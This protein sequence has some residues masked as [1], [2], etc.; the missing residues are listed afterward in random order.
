MN[1]LPP[2]DQPG[3]F[4]PM[5]A[6]PLGPSRRGLTGAAVPPG[7]TVPAWLVAVLLLTVSALML[8]NAGLIPSLSS[9]AA[10][11]PRPVTPRGNLA[12]DEKSTIEIFR[13]ASPSVVH[14]TTVTHRRD[15]L[16]L[17]VTEIPEGT[18]T[19]FIYDGEGHV[20]TNFH[21]IRSAQAAKVTLADNST[22]DARLVGY[23]PNKDLAVLRID[24]S[25]DRLR[26]IDI[27]QSSD[28]QVGQKVFAIGCPFGLDQ[29]LTTGV[30]SGLGR[31]ITSIG[32]RPIE[33]VIQTD[34]AINPGNSGGP[35]LDSAGRLIGVNT[36]IISPSG[37]YAGVGFA[38][39]VDIVNQVVPELIQHGRVQRAILGVSLFEDS[40]ARRLGVRKGALVREVYDSTGAAAAGIKSTFI[41]E[42]GEIQLGDVITE[43]AG[44]T[45]RVV[46][47]I[48]KALDGKKPGEEVQVVVER[49]GKPI[50]LT[51]EL[52]AATTQN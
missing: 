1:Q 26:E 25:K 48:S 47:D 45:I 15:R 44:R 14:I 37:G 40:L 21:V 39:P 42:D 2:E 6:S 41:D 18:G 43:L 9:P 20:V 36:M 23:E 38:V 34:A 27:G 8:R 16:S 50:S 12:D 35:L 4:N 49:D 28:L 10:V 5:G 17:N 46:S 52:Q 3:Q 13:R 30:I 11:Q 32:G 51:V 7:P 22:W 33:G 31:E 24:A 29:T 19:G